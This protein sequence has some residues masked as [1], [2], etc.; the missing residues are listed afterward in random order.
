MSRAYQPVL[1]DC[2][3]HWSESLHPASFTTVENAADLEDLRIALGAERLNLV[4]ISYGTHLG[5]AYIRQYPD[6][7]AHAVLAGVEGPDHTYKR[8]AEG[9]VVDS[10][11][12]P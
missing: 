7:V 6:R 5:L 2:W 10:L 1:R 8:P 3:D 4:G 11:P 12:A 9:T